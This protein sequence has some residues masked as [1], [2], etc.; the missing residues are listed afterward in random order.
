MEIP[1][2]LFRLSSLPGPP[3]SPSNV[4]STT[5]RTVPQDREQGIHYY[6]SWDAVIK[7]SRFQPRNQSH[8]EQSPANDPSLC[9]HL[10]SLLEKLL[11]VVQSSGHGGTKNR[12][13]TCKTILGESSTGNG[14]IRSGR[15]GTGRL[16]PG[17]PT[18]KLQHIN[19]GSFKPPLYS[20]RVY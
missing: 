13:Q 10:Q 17:E 12:G 19:R 1:I 3:T 15:T 11:R 16:I 14:G 4:I 18:W 2:N 8:N 5:W 20:R 9:S 6:Y 7:S